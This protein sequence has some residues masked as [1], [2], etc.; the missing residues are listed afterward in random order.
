M[1]DLF[2]K[3]REMMFPRSVIAG[4][5]VLGEVG[6][7][8]RSFDFK[9]PGLVIT[10]PRT[11]EI[12]GESVAESIED[13]GFDVHIHE[14][15]AATIENVEET[16]DV[17]KET[18][19]G[20]LVGVGGGSKIDIT[21]M[22]SARLGIPFISVPTSA[23]H[24]GIAS[25][26]ASIKENGVSQSIKATVPMGVVADTE[27]IVKA[28]YRSLASGC[29]DVL[30]NI[31][32]IKDWTLAHRLRNEPISTFAMTLSEMTARIILE[33]AEMI[34]PNLEESVWVAIRPLIV[35][36]VAMSVAGTS[37][38]CSGSEHM[39]SHALDMIAPGKAM[40]GE[41]CGVGAIMML[42]L[43]GGDWKTFREALVEI[44]APTSAKSLGVSDEEIIEAL[45]KAHTVRPDRYTILGDRGLTREAAER[46]ARVTMVIE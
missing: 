1:D 11:R 38:P 13:T 27:V 35:S 12:A 6:K 8:C 23:S 31:T 41:Q 45:M 25:P 40:H 7:L 3:A 2:Q 5:G 43:H 9:S 39:F 26:I 24:D 15:G 20:F 14:T 37:R 36:G 21:K 30:S 34:K 19:A 46:L 29:A 22:T 4:H 17:A 16:V 18:K 10:G 42:Y 44:G 33:N 28:P 32:A